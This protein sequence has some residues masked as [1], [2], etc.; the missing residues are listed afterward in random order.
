MGLQVK[1]GPRSSSWLCSIGTI[2]RTDDRSGAPP[3]R[4][5]HEVGCDTGLE[6]AGAWAGR[7][8]ISDGGSPDEAAERADATLRI[9]SG[10]DPSP[11]AVVVPVGGGVDTDGVVTDG[12]VTDGVVTDGV[13]TDG[14]DASGGI[15]GAGII[16]GGG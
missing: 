15:S 4:S 12:V 7:P 10:T 16:A 2:L 6:L 11:R 5:C 13:V 14:V 9:G 1:I 3:G 8:G